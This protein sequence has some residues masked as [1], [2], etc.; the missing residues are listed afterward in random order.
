MS[1]SY[2]VVNKNH[3]V[4]ADDFLIA[5]E[6]ILKS[7]NSNNYK[8]MQRDDFLIDDA[9]ELIGYAYIASENTKY[10]IALANKYSN[11]TQNALLKI[12]EE[13]PKNIVIILVAKNR[14]IF[15]PTIRSRLIVQDIKT[16]KITKEVEFDF[17]NLNLVSIYD[18]LKDNKH[19]SKDESKAL[20]EEAFNFYTKRELPHNSK[21]KEEL[22]FF[23]HSIRLIELNSP[24]IGVISNLLLIMHEQMKKS[25]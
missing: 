10:I 14:A 3:I 1:L 12:L 13:P 8:L 21:L 5:Q 18:F 16:T 9:H 2:N 24:N 23:D 19:I 25:G 7:I 4:I 11:V 22:D 20:I 17:E 6:S 15:L